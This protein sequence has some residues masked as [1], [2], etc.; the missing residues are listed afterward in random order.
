MLSAS[1][2][3]LFYLTFV[4]S[5]PCTVFPVLYIALATHHVLSHSS[6]QFLNITRLSNRHKVIAQFACT[7]VIFI[8]LSYNRIFWSR[9]GS[10]SR[11]FS[12]SMESPS[13][14]LDRCENIFEPGDCSILLTPD[15][16]K[17]GGQ[18]WR[19]VAARRAGVVPSDGCVFNNEP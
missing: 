13:A 17:L 12:L 9:W 16:P 15:F 5:V 6:L 1:S 7:S 2:S 19:L 10:F 11:R 4:I 3:M 14:Q 8:L 18:R